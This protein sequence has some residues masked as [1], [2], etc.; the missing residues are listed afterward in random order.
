MYKI[1]LWFS[2]PK[3]AAIFSVLLTLILTLS[4]TLPF[5]SRD[6][7][8]Y[9][10]K[11]KT[12]EL[13]TVGSTSVTSSL[14]QLMYG[15]EETM[16][17]LNIINTYE[18]KTNISVVWQAGHDGSGSAFKQ[19]SQYNSY[20]GFQ[21]REFKEEEAQNWGY[22][23]SS[24]TFEEEFYYDSFEIDA[25]GHVVNKETS[26]NLSLNNLSEDDV[27][28]IYYQDFDNNTQLIN[29]YT[30][31]ANSG[32]YEAWASS[33]NVEIGSEEY[34]YDSNVAE[35]NNNDKMMSNIEAEDDSVGYVSLSSIDDE[36]NL[37]ILDYEGV[38]AT[39]E[40]ILSN[41][42]KLVRNFNIF[43]RVSEEDSHNWTLW[44]EGWTFEALSLMKENADNEEQILAFLFYN[45]VLFSKDAN[46]ITSYGSNKYDSSN[47]MD[48][49]DIERYLF[50][51]FD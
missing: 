29:A 51:M 15:N 23:I 4:I 37:V 33:I 39:K 22:D 20:I 13:K 46:D 40:N 21:S 38:E 24:P 48:I 43:F 25:I 31:D 2:N 3:F 1:K 35:V 7:N 26:D 12:I 14:Y 34:K 28:G 11:L 30:R 17:F 47:Y 8:S 49:E 44:T 9:S 45:W 16:G 6:N 10:N 5:I 19:Q 50:F 41:D 18:E 27:K 36:S 32:T 42:Y